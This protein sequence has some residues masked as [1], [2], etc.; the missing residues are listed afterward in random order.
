MQTTF[1]AVILFYS[2]VFATYLKSPVISLSLGAGCCCH[3]CPGNPHSQSFIYSLRNK[4]SKS[5]PVRIL[6][7]LWDYDNLHKKAF[8]KKSLPTSLPHLQSV[9]VNIKIHTECYIDNWNKLDIET[10]TTSIFREYFKHPGS[11]KVVNQHEQ[12]HSPR[13]QK[14]KS[15]K[16]GA[17]QA[18]ES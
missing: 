4:W 17:P 5:S 7:K 1:H 6:R 3:V 13:N 11:P 16:H 8:G 10:R 9:S 14:I 18:T 12:S 15:L 2:S